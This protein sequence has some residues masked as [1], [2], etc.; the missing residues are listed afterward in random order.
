VGLRND[1][2]FLKEWQKK[3]EGAESRNPVF[4]FFKSMTQTVTQFPPSIIAETRV[5]ICQLV[6]QMEAKDLHEQNQAR[7]SGFPFHTFSSSFDYQVPCYSCHGNVP[8]A[9]CQSFAQMLSTPS[10]VTDSCSHDSPSE[11]IPTPA[12]PQNGQEGR[13]S[14][15]DE[16]DPYTSSF[17]DEFKFR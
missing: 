15:K 3:T 9:P 5:K 14:A 13:S 6:A 17:A 11:P 8:P 1:C 7:A 12:P 4:T 2:K 10:P 16:F